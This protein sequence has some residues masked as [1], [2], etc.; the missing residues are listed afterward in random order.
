LRVVL[1]RVREIY[2]WKQ[3]IYDYKAH[4]VGFYSVK[5]STSWLFGSLLFCW[6]FNAEYLPAYLS[7]FFVA[8]MLNNLKSRISG[9]SIMHLLQ[10]SERSEAKRAVEP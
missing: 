7:L 5:L 6:F 1:V 4:V 8:F 3:Q 10:V 2:K 9:S